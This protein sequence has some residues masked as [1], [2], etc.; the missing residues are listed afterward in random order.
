MTYDDDHPARK[1][2]PWTSHAAAEDD[3]ELRASQRAR[4]LATYSDGPIR[5]ALSDEESAALAGLTPPAA[6]CPWKRSGE[7]RRAGEIVVV[8]HTVS[9]HG[10]KVQ[11]CALP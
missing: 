7:L 2:D 8:G 3:R 5:Y 9:S 6:S 4:L 11:I 10:K 1:S